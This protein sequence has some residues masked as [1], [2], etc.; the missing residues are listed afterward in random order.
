MAIAKNLN[1]L[2]AYYKSL[3]NKILKSNKDID[4][5]S[6]IDSLIDSKEFEI[7]LYLSKDKILGGTS[8]ST[9]SRCQK[10][11]PGN[12]SFCPN[13]CIKKFL[14]DKN[15]IIK[16]TNTGGCTSYILLDN[17]VIHRK[18]YETIITTNC[19]QLKKLL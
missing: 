16:I 17:L 15:D 5:E 19:N 1:Y 2:K 13:C 9:C 14:F 8:L 6:L 10:I 18:E 4:I 12:S 7:Q 11:A 3:I